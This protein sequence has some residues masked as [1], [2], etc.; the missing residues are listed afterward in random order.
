MNKLVYITGILTHLSTASPPLKSL[1]TLISD[2]SCDRECVGFCLNYFPHHSILDKCGC[3]N[4][5]A[6]H[7]KF[8]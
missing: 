5:T 8:F 6:S 7:E 2:P 4:P 3:L 1:E